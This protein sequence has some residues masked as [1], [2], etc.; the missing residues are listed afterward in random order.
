MDHIQ[1]LGFFAP[2]YRPDLE[3]HVWGPASA[4]LRLQARL[5]R[6]LSPPLFPVSLSELPCKLTFHDVPCG[7]DRHRRI[8]RVLGAGV[9]PRPHGGVPHHGAR[10]ARADLPARPRARARRAALPDPAA[11]VDFGRHAGRGRRPAD[12]RRPVQRRRVSRP[13]RLGT[14]LARPHARF[15]NAHRGEAARAVPPRSR[16]HRHRP[17]P[18]DV[19]RPS[20]TRSPAIRS[21]PGSRAPCSTSEPGGA[22]AHRKVRARTSA[23][24]SDR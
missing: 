9:P 3:V 13:L 16:P 7:G 19:R 8:P 15:R 2:L 17:R 11:G 20:K 14:Q 21:H 24:S 18:S 12:P 10:R 23:V 1:G 22:A 5:R 4:T 6:Y